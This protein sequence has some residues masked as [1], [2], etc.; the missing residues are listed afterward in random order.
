MFSRYVGR[1]LSK[2]GLS[3]QR[4][5]QSEAGAITFPIFDGP[6]PKEIREHPGMISHYERRLLY[7]L[8]RERY[9]GKGVIVDAGVF[10]GASTIAF[11]RG[12]VE[13]KSISLNEVPQPPLRSFDRAV[14][15]PNFS[16]HSS[17]GGI[18]D[19]PVG[20]SFESVLREQIQPYS[21]LTQLYVGDIR[22]YRGDDI[23][24]I[25]ICFLDVLKNREVTFHVMRT[26]FPK[27]IPSSIIVQQDYFFSD[28]PHIRVLTEALSDKLRY[29][30]EVRSSAVFQCMESI[31]GDDLTRAF[32]ALECVDQSVEL[33]QR[34]EARTTSPLRQYILRL[35]RSK[36]YALA[37]DVDLARQTL[38]EANRQFSD[39][40]S[41]K[42]GVYDRRMGWRLKLLQRTIDRAARKQAAKVAK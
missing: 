20:E 41:T 10:L 21:N 24:S 34:A 38:A 15:G 28:L 22:D 39:V 19:V 37:N 3:S 1:C 36:L 26:L 4:P 35:S 9:R 2:L 16:R 5:L 11:G 18:P 12:L 40:V 25:E 30:G 6:L 14:A 23:A 33:H 31:T 29:L 32:R 8:A 7:G 17:K 42:S 13:N 27:L